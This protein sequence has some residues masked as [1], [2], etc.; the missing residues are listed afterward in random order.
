MTTFANTLQ[1]ILTV[2]GFG[3]LVGYHV[4]LYVRLS[5]R[6][7]TTSIGLANRMRARWVQS[8]YR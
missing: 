5:R 1:I 8:Y 3:I 4:H 6:P 2:A 7:D